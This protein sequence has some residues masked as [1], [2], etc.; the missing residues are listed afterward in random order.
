MTLI[1]SINCTL[2]L[3]VNTYQVIYQLPNKCSKLTVTFF[4]RK[5]LLLSLVM[6]LIRC[7]T[8]T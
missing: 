3:F 4:L 7:C 6:R 8:T 1:N 2:R 5:F